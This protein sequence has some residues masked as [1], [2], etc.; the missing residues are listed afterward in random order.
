M[1]F[2]NSLGGT[3]YTPLHLAAAGGHVVVCALLLD[4]LA[5]VH[6]Q[7]DGIT[8]LSL[9]RKM[10]N[11]EVE[12]VIERHVAWM[13]VNMCEFFFWCWFSSS[14]PQKFAVFSFESAFSSFLEGMAR[15]C[16]LLAYSPVRSG[17]DTPL[18]NAVGRSREL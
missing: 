4:A 14:A 6:K 1:V 11:M 9:A 8:A 16:C 17:P 10:G 18:I 12:E 13:S 3:G 7:V 15:S 2:H 5:D